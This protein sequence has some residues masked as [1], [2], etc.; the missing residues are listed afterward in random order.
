MAAQILDGRWVATQIQKS[1]QEKVTHLLEKGLRPPALAVIL[2]GQDAASAIYVHNKR[3][4]C[5]AVGFTSYAHD[6]PSNISEAALL[7]LISHLNEDETIDG[8]LVQLP[9]PLHI[10]TSKIIEA[11]CP[12]KDVDGFH[13]YNLGRLA[14][15]SPLLRPCTPYGIIQLL[16]WYQ[17]NLEGLNAVVVGASNIV[18]R[19]MALELLMA[20]S[21]V[22][23]CH[24]CTKNLEKHVT[25]AD[26]LVVAA[27]KIDLIHPTWI[28]N[29]AIVIDVGIHRQANGKIRGDIDFEPAAKRAAWITPVPFGVGPMTISTLLHNTLLCMETST[30]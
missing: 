27:G 17:L 20:G 5:Q 15:K 23:V 19:P 4:A 8:I 7:D 22:T 30:R 12:E 29:G 3:K 28:K 13:P 21:T 25:D 10:D 11:I 2:V 14:Q 1:L 24:D 26:L 18:G 6:L 9:L 16:A